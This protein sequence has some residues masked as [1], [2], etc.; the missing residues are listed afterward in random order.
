MSHSL[1]LVI[2]PQEPNRVQPSSA[3]DQTHPKSLRD[4]QELPARALGRAGISHKHA[5]AEM[6]ISPGQL[7]SQ[8][9]GREHLS[10]WRM[11]DLPAGFWS[12]LL[13][14][15]SEWYGLSFGDNAQA[16]RDSVLGARVREVVA[17][18]V[19]PL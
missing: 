1:P 7:S 17:L 8:L 6:G 18:L 5:A 16:R 14:M 13:P 10:L 3:S 15:L 12:E 11:K 9:S 4:W 2:G 19:E